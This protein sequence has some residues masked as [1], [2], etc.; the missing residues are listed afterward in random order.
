MSCE[1]SSGR[2]LNTLARI[3]RKKGFSNVKRG[4]HTIL[5]KGRDSQTGIPHRLPHLIFSVP[6]M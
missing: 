4:V 3:D 2:H 5:L 6:C 1:R